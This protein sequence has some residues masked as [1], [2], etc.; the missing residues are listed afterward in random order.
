MIKEINRL[1]ARHHFP[2]GG[3]MM[4]TTHLTPWSKAI[5]VCPKGLHEG[6]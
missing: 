5:D 1:E 4:V 6:L 2:E 3:K